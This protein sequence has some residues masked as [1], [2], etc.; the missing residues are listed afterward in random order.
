MNRP[1][2]KISVSPRF[3]LGDSLVGDTGQHTQQY[4]IRD[5]NSFGGDVLRQ[6]RR[7]STTQYKKELDQISHQLQGEPPGE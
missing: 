4:A 7:E 5:S 2:E 3:R 1:F 6:V